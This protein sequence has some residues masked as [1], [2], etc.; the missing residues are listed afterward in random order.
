MRIQDK[1]D[2]KTDVIYVYTRYVILKR[3]KYIRIQDTCDSKTD[4]IYAYYYYYY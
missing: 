1:C 4:V 2:Y 3:M